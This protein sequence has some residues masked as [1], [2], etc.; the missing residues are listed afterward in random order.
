MKKKRKK[1]HFLGVSLRVWNGQFL[2]LVSN[3]NPVK[4]NPGF[5][6]EVSFGGG[7]S[8]RKLRCGLSRMRMR[9]PQRAV[10]KGHHFYN[11]LK[12]NI[13]A[14]SLAAR[15]P[16]ARQ[17]SILDIQVPCSYQVPGQSL[18]GTGME[19]KTGTKI[20]ALR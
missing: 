7:D 17:L 19:K 1:K 14:S 3:P 20:P 4:K 16:A 2:I 12:I 5:H 6:L 10:L 13:K 9:A 8:C 11:V 15:H 18:R